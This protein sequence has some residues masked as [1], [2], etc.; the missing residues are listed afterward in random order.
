MKRLFQNQSTLSDLKE[1]IPTLQESK[2]NQ[3]AGGFLGISGKQAK[4]R[5]FID[6]VCPDNLVCPDNMFCLDTTP[7]S[8]ATPLS[9]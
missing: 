6:G 3:L 7:T 1:N 8:T 5:G 9:L 2:E 4:A